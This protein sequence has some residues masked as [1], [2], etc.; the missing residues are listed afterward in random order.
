MEASYNPLKKKNQPPSNRIISND[1]RLQ[2]ADDAQR[3]CHLE[4][5]AFIVIC[6]MAAC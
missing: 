6:D 5:A 3:S 4:R 2:P 1:L